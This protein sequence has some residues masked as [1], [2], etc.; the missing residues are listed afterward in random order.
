MTPDEECEKGSEII[1]QCIDCKFKG[2]KNCLVCSF[3][4]C[5]LCEYNYLLN[6]EI[7]ICTINFL[8]TSVEECQKIGIGCVLNGNRC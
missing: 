8:N 4:V 5:S 6:S 3:E 1:E 2:P 7:N